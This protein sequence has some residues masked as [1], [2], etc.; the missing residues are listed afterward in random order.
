MSLEAIRRRL[1]DADIAFIHDPGGNVH[2]WKLRA[3]SAITY[4]GLE[5]ATYPTSWRQLKHTW[6]HERGGAQY[7]F[8]GHEYH[9]LGGIDLPPSED[10]CVITTSYYEKQTQY[11]VNELIDRHTRTDGTLVVIADEQRF[12]PIGG[13]RPLYQEQFCERIGSYDI[14]YDAFEDYYEEEGWGLPLLDT[15]NLFLQDNANIYELVECEGLRTTREL[16]DVLTDAPYLPL[17]STFSEIFARRDQLGVAP[18]E[19]DE[20][21]EAFG[22]WLRRRIEWEKGTA[23]AIARDLNRTV[24]MGGTAFDPSY[25]KRSPKLGD[26]RDAAKSVDPE[27]N[28]IEARYYDWLSNT[29]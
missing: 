15:K 13:L 27:A 14:V 20:I 6:Q 4:L 21:I 29:L 25:A 1:S 28:D 18:L 23:S 8:P 3:L 24:S 5:H 11:T 22:G 16:F 10:L 26:A 9:V 12:Q 7:A 19:S 17:Y 2:F